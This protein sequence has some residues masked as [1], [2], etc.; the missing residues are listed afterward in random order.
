MI[1]WILII[2]QIFLLFAGG[3]MVS[4]MLYIIHSF[5][6]KVPYVPVPKGVVKRMVL[7]IPFILKNDSVHI[8]DLG[9]GTGKLVCHLARHTPRHVT[10]HGVEKSPLLF[11]ISRVRRFLSPRKKRIILFKADWNTVS[12]TDFYAV[13]VFLTPAGMADL[14]PKFKSE[15]TGSAYIASYLFPL[16]TKDGFSEHK[17]VWGKN[18]RIYVYTKQDSRAVHT[19]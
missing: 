19:R 3:L 6:H 14:Y 8:I 10:V 13:F 5:R 7:A 11:F 4:R 17:I 9:S 16:Q 12:L 18:E 2:F 15:L 1:E